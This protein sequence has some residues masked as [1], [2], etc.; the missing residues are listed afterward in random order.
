MINQDGLS[1]DFFFVLSQHRPGCDPALNH[2]AL[3]IPPTISYVKGI[4]QNWFFTDK[5]GI[6][7]RKH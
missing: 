5:R 4:P 3:L 2:L 1:R 7:R 6:L